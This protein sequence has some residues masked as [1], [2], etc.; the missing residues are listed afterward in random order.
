MPCLQGGT[1]AAR[2]R[3]PG[4]NTS[5]VSATRA[6]LARFNY[7][8]AGVVEID[9]RLTAAS[10]DGLG[11]LPVCADSGAMGRKVA[12]LVC[13]ASGQ[14]G[15]ADV[16]V[17]RLQGDGN[18]F[19]ALV[20]PASAMGLQECAVTVQPTQCTTVAAVVCL[21]PLF[22]LDYDPPHDNLFPYRSKGIHFEQYS[23]EQYE[24][25]LQPAD[26]D[27]DNDV[28]L[29]YASPDMVVWYE[30]ID[31]KGTF[32]VSHRHTITT[33]FRGPAYCVADVDGDGDHDFWSVSGWYENTN[34]RGVFVSN[35]RHAVNTTWDSTPA[36]S[37][38]ATDIDGDGDLDFVAAAT[39]VAWFENLDGR[40]A[41]YVHTISTVGAYWVS[42]TDMD[43]DGDVDVLVLHS[44]GGTLVWYENMD[45]RG[46]FLASQRHVIASSIIHAGNLDVDGDGDLDIF[47]YTAVSL[48]LFENEN[49]KHSLQQDRL[50]TPFGNA[51]TF[52]PA[53]VDH[54]GDLDILIP[55]S[56]FYFYWMEEVDGKFQRRTAS[57]KPIEDNNPG[58]FL[59]RFIAAADL[60]GDGD[61]DVILWNSGKVRS[62]EW[63]E[64][65]VVFGPSQPEWYA[66]IQSPNASEK[67]TWIIVPQDRRIDGATSA[68]LNRDGASD[69]LSF[70]TS[71]NSISWHSNAQRD[72]TFVAM[73]ICSSFL[74]PTVVTVSDLDGDGDLDVLAAT[75]SMQPDSLVW[76][77]NTN[78][79]GTFDV[80]WTVVATFVYNITSIVTADLDGDSTTDVL[81]ASFGNGSIGWH[82]NIDGQGRFQFDNPIMIATHAAEALV[83]RCTFFIN[84]HAYTYTIG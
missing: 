48:M 52:V 69:V 53:D 61:M 72:G 29:V 19:G 84:G 56:D 54:D 24:V 60:D 70:S 20:C 18:Y 41:F 50:D 34:G 33:A 22:A 30:N 79:Q 17:E 6:Y 65:T 13:R 62:V 39:P 25:S 76:F 49:G 16:F 44:R 45:G 82:R 78:G 51:A 58:F 38:H 8:L 63:F 47:V 71:Q 11:F 43:D 2:V 55:S 67:L 23:T 12:D 1:L 83:R 5:D 81:W 42:A 73:G 66:S 3:P 15:V 36:M 46:Q 68:D 75:A 74:S 14:R 40:G 77:N 32:P 35:H 27:G 21:Q 37:V 57:R 10:Q 59:E 80:S 4:I 7:Q 28:D 64:N 31:A 26:M 9:V